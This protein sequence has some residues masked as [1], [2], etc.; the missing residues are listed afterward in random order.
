[1][2]KIRWAVAAL[3]LATAVGG[4]HFE[5]A[6]AAKKIALPAARAEELVTL[7]TRALEAWKSKDA[8]VW[9][10]LL[11][12]NFVGFGSSGRLNKAL[13]KNEFLQQNCDIKSYALSNMQFKPLESDAA[14]LT[15]K[16]TTDGSCDGHRLPNA[17]WAA[18]VYV[19]DGHKWK[20]V[21]HA[22]S[23]VVDLTAAATNPVMNPAVNSEIFPP[24][25]ARR[26]NRTAKLAAMSG[27]ERAVW[28]DWRKHDGEKIAKLTAEDISFINIFGMFLP[29]KAEALKNWSGAGCDVKR[30]SVNDAQA[31][32]LSPT[33]GI[34]TFA[35]AGDGTC[36]GQPV[37]R[38]WGTTIYVS[39]GTAWKW[40]FGI[41]TP[42]LRAGI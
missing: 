18:S 27:V 10:S 37:G 2:G 28:E 22:A 35:G 11:A 38:V 25:K 21:F 7:E 16:V 20:A 42:A 12:D 34:L 39:E 14:L 13:A 9:D 3:A 19:R 26:A 32:M 29:T 4:L 31:T 30:V 8:K 23:P 36:Y 33:V 40:T 41:N 15:Y 5:N 24:Q 6:N 1:M 17:A